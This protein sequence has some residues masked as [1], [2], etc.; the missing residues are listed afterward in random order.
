[1]TAFL[2]RPRER[3]KEAHRRRRDKSAGRNIGLTIAAMS[4]LCRARL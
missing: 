2:Q 3:E 4:R 1:M